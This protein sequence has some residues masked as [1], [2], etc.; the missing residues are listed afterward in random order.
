MLVM[1]ERFRTEDWDPF[2]LVSLCHSSSLKL[3]QPTISIN[4]FSIQNLLYFFM[5]SLIAIWPWLQTQSSRYE[6]LWHT[7]FSFFFLFRKRKT[8]TF[9]IITGMSTWPTC[10]KLLEEISSPSF[11][12]SS[13]SSSSSSTSC[14]SNFPSF[15]GDSELFCAVS[16]LNF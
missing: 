3:S 7:L 16:L 12:S 11:G 8:G 14:S 5:K 15:E 13:S 1:K 6:K 4:S 10:V 9:Y 2:F